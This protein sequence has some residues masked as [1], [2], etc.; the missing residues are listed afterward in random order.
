M[1]A[2]ADEVELLWAL[3]RH[4]YGA[5]LDEAQIKI[6][7]ETLEGLARDVAALRGAKIP[8]DVE[9]AQPF[10]PFRAEP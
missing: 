5:R 9:P 1:A 10:I 2:I 8:D 3:V 6:V 7:R 4:R